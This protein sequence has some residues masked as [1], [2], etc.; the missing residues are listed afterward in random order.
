MRF[1]DHTHLE[2]RPHA[3]VACTRKEKIRRKQKKKKKGGGNGEK[4]KKKKERTKRQ[5]QRVSPDRAEMSVL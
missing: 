3:L 2:A 5:K 1:L 4:T